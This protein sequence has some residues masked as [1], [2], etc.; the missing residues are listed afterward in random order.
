[1]FLPAIVELVSKTNE[2]SLFF[3]AQRIQDHVKL[4]NPSQNKEKYMKYFNHGKI[5]IF[6]KSCSENNYISKY[7]RLNGI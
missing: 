2:S 5:Q 4:S 1:M 6:S 7:Y 3:L